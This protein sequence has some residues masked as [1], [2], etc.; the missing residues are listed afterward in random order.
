MD[1]VEELQRTLQWSHGKKL[2]SPILSAAMSLQRHRCSGL[3]RSRSAVTV[4]GLPRDAVASSQGQVDPRS[5]V[6]A[7]CK[8][9]ICGRTPTVR[10]RLAPISRAH[11]RLRFQGSGQCSRASC[12]REVVAQPGDSWFGDIS[13]PPSFAASNGFR[14]RNCPSRSRVPSSAR[15]GSTGGSRGAVIR[16]TDSERCS[17]TREYLRLSR[18]SQ[19]CVSTHFCDLKLDRA[20][21]LSLHDNGPRIDMVVVGD[22]G[23]AETQ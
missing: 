23:E 1:P 2:N 22:V 9:T 19:E 18:P 10:L 15:C 3:L 13:M 4:T 5:R 7:V 14:R 12:G 6:T 16:L 17:Q 21:C 11:R 8:P 20:L